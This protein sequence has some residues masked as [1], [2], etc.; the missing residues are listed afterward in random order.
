[1]LE[2]ESEIFWEAEI[3][4]FFFR[5]SGGDAIEVSLVDD[6]ERNPIHEIRV[7]NMETIK[8]FHKE[9]SFWYLTDSQNL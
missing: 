3:K 4:Q 8:D 2:D 7:K 5:Y 1:M 6:K 9:I